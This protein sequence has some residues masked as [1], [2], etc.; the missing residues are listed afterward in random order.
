MEPI[1]PAPL[2]CPGTETI[3]LVE[4]DSAVQLLTR[5]ALEASGYRVLIASS[6][7]Q[8]LEIWQSE[9]AEIDLLIVALGTQGRPQAQD[10]AKQLRKRK[11]GLSV[12]AIGGGTSEPSAEEDAFAQLPKPYRLRDLLEIVRR[13]LDRASSA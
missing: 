5:Q 11:P 2:L 9:S 1:N 10:L 7:G 6:A 4:E 3:L 12:L 8:A 13:S